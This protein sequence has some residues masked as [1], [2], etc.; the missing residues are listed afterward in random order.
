MGALRAGVKR[1]EADAAAALAEARRKLAALDEREAELK[2]EVRLPLAHDPD[3]RC[4]CP[5][6]RACHGA[7]TAGCTATAPRRLSWAA[8]IQN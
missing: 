8:A 6:R 3:L 5:G 4:S 1:Q 2:E 7:C